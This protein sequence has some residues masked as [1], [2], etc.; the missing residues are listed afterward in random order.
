MN[1]KGWPL[2]L[3]I[4]LFVVSLIILGVAVAMMTG[5]NK[6][7]TTLCED[8]KGEINFQQDKLKPELFGYS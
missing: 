8:T 5:D 4:G 1:W 6:E 7:E 3:N 2:A